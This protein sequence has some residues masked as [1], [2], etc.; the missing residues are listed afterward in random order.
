MMT[1]TRNR[2][3]GTDNTALDLREQRLYDKVRS[4]VTEAVRGKVPPKLQKAAELLLTLPDF[5]VLIFRLVKDPRVPLKAKV[6]LCLFIA[7]LASPIDLLPDVIPVVGQMDDL[8]GAVIVVRD[9]LTVTPKEVVLSHWSGHQDVIGLIETVLEVAPEV[10]G[11]DILTG[12]LK[13]F[14]IRSGRRTS[15][16]GSSTGPS[17]SSPTPGA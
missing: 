13:R 9:L 7:Y 11:K 5:V 8:V 12:L 6:K 2:G 17:G 4:K 16:N 10:L 15:E 14:A 3:P 1:E